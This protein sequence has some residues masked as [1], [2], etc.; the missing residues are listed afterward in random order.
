MVI[1]GLIVFLAILVL[2]SMKFYQLYIKKDHR[3]HSLHMLMPLLF[4]LTVFNFFMGMFG[5]A[6]ELFISSGKGLMVMSFLLITVTADTPESFN[7]LM[8]TV[9]AIMKSSSIALFSIFV[10][11][12][13]VSLWFL[14]NN[15]ILKIQK[16]EASVLLTQ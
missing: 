9:D 4:F 13:S 7:F 2:A 5:Y 1:P 6:Y 15:K 3:V 10:T 16:A 12:V 11:L 14:L 8:E